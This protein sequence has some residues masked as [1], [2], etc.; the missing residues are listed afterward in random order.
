MHRLASMSDPC[1]IVKRYYRSFSH[2]RG[3]DL[4]TGSGIV[5]CILVTTMRVAGG[6]GGVQKE[7]ESARCSR[8]RTHPLCIRVLYTS[9]TCMSS[10]A[11]AR[12]CDKKKKKR[13]K[14]D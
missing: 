2:F 6:G 4:D 14:K 5:H 3:G 12:A 7:G 8:A 1:M 13:E 10:R 9:I 11:R